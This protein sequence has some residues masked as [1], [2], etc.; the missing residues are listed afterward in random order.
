MAAEGIEGLQIFGGSA[1]VE[2]A[3]KVAIELG[4]TAVAPGGE[5]RNGEVSCDLPDSIR[6]QDVFV[7]ASHCAYQTDKGSNP[8]DTGRSP[9][10]AFVEQ[11]LIVSAAR[12]SWARRV[13]AVAP[14]AGFGR[15]DRRTGRQ[16][17]TA[18]LAFDMIKRAG[19]DGMVSVDLHSAQA[20]GFFDGPFEHLTATPTF[21][22]YINTT[23]KGDAIAIVSPDNGRVKHA[24]RTRDQLGDRGVLAVIDKQRNP[25][26]TAAATHIVGADVAGLAC[27]IVDDMIDGA[28]TVVMAAN[29]VHERGAK[30][31]TVMATHGVFS[32]AARE[33]LNDSP[34][35]S[36]VITDTI[37][38]SPYMRELVRPKITVVSIAGFLAKAI[39]YMHQGKSVE[40]LH[41]GMPQRI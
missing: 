30:S 38:L 12:S 24:G 29:K 25:D 35:D 34:I 19:A 21:V 8:H 1:S 5:F 33:R 14:F 9:Q 16:P 17:I 23:Y 13:V 11:A 6:G 37:P 20:E 22:N 36:V 27:I 26:G 41:P 39:Q 18:R 40:S 10:D 2:L 7:I 32:G 28:G 31:V 15:Q 3:Q 4:T